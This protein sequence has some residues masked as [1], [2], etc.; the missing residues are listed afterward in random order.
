MKIDSL[1]GE[2]ACPDSTGGSIDLLVR[3]PVGRRAGP[4]IGCGF[5]VNDRFAKAHCG[6]CR[7]KAEAR[8]IR[9]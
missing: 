3:K 5:G 8:G 9:I 2:Q 7:N 4:S 1:A 6:L